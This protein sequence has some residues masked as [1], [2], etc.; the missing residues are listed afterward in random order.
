VLTTPLGQGSANEPMRGLISRAEDR[1]ATA[2]VERVSLLPGFPYSDVERCGF[3]ILAVATADKADA[4]LA[5]VADTARDV[6]AHRMEFVV[7]RSRPADAVR[8]A[9]ARDAHPVILADVADNVGG[10]SPGDGTALLA[11]LIAQ[12]ARGAIVII[13]DAEAVATARLAGSGNAIEI[14]LGGKSD[15]MHGAPV[16]VRGE[17]AH[18]SDGIYR[19]SGSWMTGQEFSMGPT[20][21]LELDEGI[22][23]VVTSRA[24]PP[25]HLEQLT[26]NG[27][28]P[29]R[30]AI[31]T[32]KGAIA[33]RAAY[34]PI[35]ASAIEV[36]TPGCCP[37]DPA[38][39]PRRHAPL[40][41]APTIPSRSRPGRQSR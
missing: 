15:A 25:F 19:T 20:A 1:A 30:A 34:G 2:G 8:D 4:A 11:E 3:G 32:A 17:I 31:I 28:D 21:V 13:A 18:L 6:E 9:L 16:R 37:I 12:K 41:V 27:I 33:W 39:L 35:M 7:T 14:D 10:G 5:V 22:I 29:T 38:S 36:D 26:S 23:V 24:V 40:A